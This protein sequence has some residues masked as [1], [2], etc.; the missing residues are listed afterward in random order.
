MSRQEP[1]L[2][3]SYDHYFQNAHEYAQNPRKPNFMHYSA[4]PGALQHA[5]ATRSNSMNLQQNKSDQPQI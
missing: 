3:P 1:T 4:T 2:Y 5:P